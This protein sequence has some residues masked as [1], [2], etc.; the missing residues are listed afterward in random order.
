M[1]CKA[2]EDAAIDVRDK[3]VERKILGKRDF[4]KLLNSAKSTYMKEQPPTSPPTVTKALS[5]TDKLNEEIA[6]VK[7]ENKVVVVNKSI[8]TFTSVRDM[9]YYYANQF[10]HDAAGKAIG[11]VISNEFRPL[12]A[13][14]RWMKSPKRDTYDSVVFDPNPAT[15]TKAFNLYRGISVEP[16]EGDCDLILAHIYR[17]WCKENTVAYVYVLNWLAHMVQIPWEPAGSIITLAGKEGAGKGV[18]TDM[19]VD[20]FE[21]HSLIAVKRDDVVGKFNKA[22][23]LSI[24]VLLNEAIWGGH[25]EEEG[26]LKALA[27]D[28]HMWFEQK[29]I[30]KVKTRN[31][32]HAIITSNNDWYAPLGAADRRYLTLRTDDSIIGNRAYFD[33]LIMQ[34]NNGGSEAFLHYLL[35]RDI[36]DFVVADIPKTNSTERAALKVENLK[37]TG[38]WLIELIEREAPCGGNDPYD[39]AVFSHDSLDNWHQGAVWIE[40][41]KLLDDCNAFARKHNMRSI[42]ANR[43]TRDMEDMLKIKPTRGSTGKRQVGFR[44]PD[45]AT[46]KTR[47]TEYLGGDSPF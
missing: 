8:S 47:I 35:H 9:Q 26:A 46:C 29:F 7:V 38:K 13:F 12:P 45:L 41:H 36:S 27:T 11:K 25:V 33:T 32:T 34:I 31:C 39:I 40:K 21:F 3:L 6:L 2:G 22:L 24:F 37:L 4:N 18:I 44:L 30:E 19:F 42:T 17:V 20:W 23:A 10:A 16:V 43:H 28:R 1:V 14:E 5:S 15:R